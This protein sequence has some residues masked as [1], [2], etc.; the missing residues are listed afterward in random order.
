MDR[1]ITE[2]DLLKVQN[3]FTLRVILTVYDC[4][5]VI[6]IALSSSIGIRGTSIG[7]TI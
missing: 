6:F 5:H 3:D 1:V 7:V 2:C 4:I